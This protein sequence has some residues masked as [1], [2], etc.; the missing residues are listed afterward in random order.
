M[1]IALRVFIE[2]FKK[3]YI[4][5]PNGYYGYFIRAYIK[6]KYIKL[7]KKT[8]IFVCAFF[9][10]GHVNAVFST[11]FALVER[12]QGEGGGREGIAQR[13]DMQKLSGDIS[14]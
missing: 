11:L 5:N 1:Y 3:Y 10:K 8:F 9:P 13:G 2:V 6:M 12:A 14:K 4:W 7:S